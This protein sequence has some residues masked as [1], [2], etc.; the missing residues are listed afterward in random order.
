MLLII[1]HFDSFIN[2]IIDYCKQLDQ[3][4]V[5]LL[6][7]QIN[8]QTLRQY[9]PQHIIIGPGPGHPQDITKVNN[10][11]EQ[12]IELNINI[13]GIC[14]G[15]QIIGQYFGAKIITAKNIFHGK[16]SK[17]MH[18]QD[19]ILKSIPINIK[20]TRYHSLVIDKNNSGKNIKIIGYSDDDQQIMAIRHNNYN[21]YGVQFH[22]ESIAS[23][24]G[25]EIL[26]NFF[27]IK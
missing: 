7:T 14:L 20:I 16:I 18:K 27:N 8:D 4:C 25:L 22:P 10:I 15:H 23:E 5:K 6:T 9:K 24:Y 3:Q 13:L 1:D 21:I 17:L 12:A 19:S 26:H 2:T 11:I